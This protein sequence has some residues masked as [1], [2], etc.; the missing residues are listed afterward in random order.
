MLE[1]IFLLTSIGLS[2]ITG[3]TI[4]IK[5]PKK[6][7][8]I[9]FAL[10]TLSFIFQSI[11]NYISLN[12]INY[13]TKL[14][15]IRFVIFFSILSVS[16]TYFLI[17]SITKEYSNNIK[18]INIVNN[19]FLIFLTVLVALL[20]LTNLVVSEIEILQNNIKPGFTYFGLSLF[21]VLLMIYF[22]KTTLFLIN[23]IRSSSDK[24][25]YKVY[26]KYL[27]FSL[28]PTYIFAPFTAV[29][30]PVFFNNDSLISLTP[31]Y[32]TVFVLAVGLLI[33]RHSL[34]DIKPILIRLIIYLF[35]IISVMLIVVLILSLFAMSFYNR[36]YVSIENILILSI[37]SLLTALI[38]QPLKIII[39]KSTD[40]ILFQYSYNSQVALNELNA[41]LVSSSK[42]QDLVDQSSKI[43]SKN[44]KTISCGLIIK[45]QKDYY[46][47][48]D[49]TFSNFELSTIYSFIDRSASRSI[50]FENLGYD[51]KNIKE[52]FRKLNISII[53]KLSV[54]NEFVG[55][56][57]L[58]ERKSGNSY[59]EK[60]IQFIETAADSIAIATQNALRYEEIAAFNANLQKKIDIATADLR[61]TNEK[62]KALDEAKDDFISMASHQLRTPLTSVKGYLSM[63][64]EGDAGPINDLQRKFLSQSFI[65]SQRMVF[66]I[67][68][69][70]NASRLKTGKFVIE[71]KETY[72]PDIVG[73][74]LSQLEETIKARGLTLEYKK[75]KSFPVVNIDENKIRQVIMNFV[76]NAIYYTP[77]GGKIV[78]KLRATH[79]VIEY[80]VQDSG[81]G[82]PKDDQKHL[83]TKFYRA[84]NAKKARPDGTGLG[85]FMAKKVIIAQGGALI[86]KSE[87]GKGSVFGFS[88]PLKKIK[89][90]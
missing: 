26:Y 85:I 54:Q 53:T 39:S 46:M 28:L 29:I 72:I 48:S 47:S 75:P 9:I 56:I 49:S 67:S 16:L 12:S 70:L 13:D 1:Q 71:N 86:F 81:I 50:L 44:L 37:V 20:S 69:L 63:V 2:F 73:E 59:T 66:L 40:K 36:D 21:L 84:G 76:D 10:A 30:L 68:D 23:K 18:S 41:A 77:S 45:G 79:E 64:L 87:E 90:K 78:V 24:S 6:S 83:F 17:I 25:R 5:N 33:I 11:F 19:Y 89:I 58:G 62:L 32:S 55:F 57:I 22:F 7:S 65:S 31:L 80:T 51:Y 82:V 3:T 60:D 35:L 52:D 8:N 38:I 42:I 27:L 15:S 43:L 88:F 61:K 4:L 34:F 74:E 14:I